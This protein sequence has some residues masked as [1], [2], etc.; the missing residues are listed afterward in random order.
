[1]IKNY[2]T[3]A[4]STLIL[5]N[6]NG[7]EEV[8]L[9]S[10]EGFEMLS[11]LWTKVAAEFKLMYELTWMGRPIIQFGSDMVMLQML[12]WESQ[13]DIFVETGIAHGG[14]L[15][16]TASLME[17]IGKGKVIGIDVEIRPHNR[18]AIE[19]HPMFKRISMIEGSSVDATTISELEKQLEPGKK[20]MVMLDS[21]H[22]R[23]HVL[24]EIELYSKYI[25]VGSYLIVQD[26]AQKWVADIPRG[27]AEW[28]HDNPLSAIDDFLAT[29]DDFIVDESYTKLGI[30]SSPGGYLKR[31]K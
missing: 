6:A 24:K 18:T 26:G 20:V 21:N 9:Y 3:E 19:A 15:I 31:I 29:N 22:S 1:M 13:P 2:Q 5:K 8:N 27:K 17:L 28:I 16:Y 4:G 10:Q 30:S 14:S 23:E 25:P 7:Q 11:N 12:L